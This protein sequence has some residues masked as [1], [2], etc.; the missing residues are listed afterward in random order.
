MRRIYHRFPQPIDLDFEVARPFRDVL[1]CMQQMHN[2]HTTERKQEGLLKRRIVIQVSDGRTKFDGLED[3]PPLEEI[4]T[5]A[6][7]LRIDLQETM[8]HPDR[9]VPVSQNVFFVRFVDKGPFT[10]CYV[11]KEGRHGEMDAM[12]IRRLLKGAC[13]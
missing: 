2:T 11:A 3:V 5:E 13:E 12:D 1:R 4:V 10:E 6:V 9:K 8:L 7:D